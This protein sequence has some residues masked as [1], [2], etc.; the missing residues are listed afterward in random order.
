MVVDIVR[1]LP[2]TP[3]W[4]S[5]VRAIGEATGAT[6]SRQALQAHPPIK[7]AYD[8]RQE[9]EPASKG[10]PRLSARAQAT[11]ER[12]TNYKRRISSLEE[13][14]ALYR[15]K[16]VLWSYNAYARG[17]SEKLFER[18]LPVIDRA[19]SKRTVSKRRAK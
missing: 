7:A 3:T 6:Y 5:I 2:G 15:E 19:R 12:E 16:F 1:R 14:V 11:M 13:E 4:K 9:G 10:G 17:L 8:A 18:D